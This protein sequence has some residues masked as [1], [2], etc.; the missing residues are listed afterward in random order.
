MLE[1]GFKPTRTVV[2]ASGFDEEVSGIR[3][4]RY[5]QLLGS[6][7][8]EGKSQGA[9]SLATAMLERFGENAFTMLVDEGCE[10]LIAGLASTMNDEDLIDSWVWRGLR[11]YH[12]NAWYWRER[13]LECTN[14]S[15][16]SRWSFEPSPASYCEHPQ[17]HFFLS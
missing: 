3:V 14:Q 12:R 17:A 8:T 4:S 7:I 1:G 5:N 13:F 15:Y 2:I 10:L 6:Y 11:Q 16:I 9:S